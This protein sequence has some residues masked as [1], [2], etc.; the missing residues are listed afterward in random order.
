[1][2]VLLQVLELLFDLFAIFLAAITLAAVTYALLQTW[3]HKSHRHL[4]AQHY[5]V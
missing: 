3:N 5:R 1:M 4:K 2:V